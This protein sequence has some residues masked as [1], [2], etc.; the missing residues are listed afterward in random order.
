M[1]TEKL[2]YIDSHLFDFEATVLDCRK[3]EKGW[4]VILDR[5]AFFPEGGGQP[6]D[7]GFIGAAPVT[8]VQERGGEI[9]HFC[10]E[11]LPVGAHLPCRIDREQRLVRMQNHSGEHIV[12]GLIHAR[13]GYENVGFQTYRRYMELW[14]K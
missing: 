14:V 11:A 13:F 1:T 3:N 7:T 5:T 2:Y 9:L 4:A 10:G 6:A 12:S 8:D